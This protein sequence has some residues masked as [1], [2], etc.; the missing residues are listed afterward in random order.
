MKVSQL[1]PVPVSKYYF[2]REGSN[3]IP[4]VSGC[5]VLCRSDGMIF[6]IGQAKNIHSRIK[7]HLN[8]PKKTRKTEYGTASVVFYLEYPKERLDALENTWIQ[9]YKSAHCGK[10]PLLNKVDAPIGL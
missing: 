3:L 4:R 10:L 6:Y 2:D 1:N 8:N 7:Q 9:S 5:Y